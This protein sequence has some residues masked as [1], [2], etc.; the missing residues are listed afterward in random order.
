MASSSSASTTTSSSSTHDNG[1]LSYFQAKL[2]ELDIIIR[3]KQQNNRRLEAQRNE[4][5]AKGKPLPTNERERA[6]GTSA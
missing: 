1:L 6:R 5:N 3:E 2:E 4:C